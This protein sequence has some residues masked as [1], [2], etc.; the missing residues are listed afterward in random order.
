VRAAR[1]LGYADARLN[2]LESSREF[3]E[4]QENKNMLAALRTAFGADETDRLM[5]EGIFWSEDQAVAE[6][7]V[8]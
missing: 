8:A 1:L 7:L 3:T 6:A 5:R 4:Q 2:E